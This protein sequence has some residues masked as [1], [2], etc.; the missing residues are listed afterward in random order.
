MVHVLQLL[1][2]YSRIIGTYGIIESSPFF[3]WNSPYLITKLMK[4]F[5]V[6]FNYMKKWS[7]SALS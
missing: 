6:L 1:K 3:I 4:D 5:F 2:L 7:S